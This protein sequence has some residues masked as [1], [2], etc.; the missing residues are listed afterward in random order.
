MD[1]KQLAELKKILEE[2]KLAL[3]EPCKYCGCYDGI[4][5]SNCKFILSL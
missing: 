2:A 5:K 1:D 3:G 4:H